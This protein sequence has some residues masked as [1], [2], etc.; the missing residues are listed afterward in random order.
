MSNRDERE[1][2]WSI[3]KRW[4]PLYSTL[5]VGQTFGW[6]TYRMIEATP[7]TALMELHTIGG[8]AAVG[9]LAVTEA[10]DIMLGTRD[11][12]NE[13]LQKRREQA[14]AEGV[15]EGVAKGHAQG[16]V[17]GV[18]KG[19]AQGVAEGHAQGAAERDMEW[20]TWNANR[21][22]A[23]ERGEP[24]DEPPPSSDDK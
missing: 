15:E 6:L 1:S 4:R 2:I 22:A 13:W 11:A 10:L 14:H 3:R 12:I 16:I 5:F 23:E 18:V 20:Q 8:R 17:E 21:I 9:T 19:H 7:E 24:F